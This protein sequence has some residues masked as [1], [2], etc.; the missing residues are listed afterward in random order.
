M[1]NL[2][3]KQ[4]EGGATELVLTVPP[5]QGQYIVVDFLDQY[6][7]TV[8]SIG[9]R[10]TPSTESQT[11][12]IAGPQSVYQHDK[13]VNIRG[14]EFRVVP[15]GTN[16]NWMLIRIRADTL[17][18]SSGPNSF[19]PNSTANVYPDVVQKFALNTLDEYLKNGNQPIFQSSFEYTFA[20]QQLKRSERWRSQPCSNRDT[21]TAADPWSSF[22]RPVAPSLSA[23]CPPRIAVSTA[24][25]WRLSPNGS[26]RKLMPPR[27]T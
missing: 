24:A 15:T 5:S 13:I 4:T 25:H 22:R 1:I 19:S 21:C 17:A 10:T 9:S 27:P 11:Y 3:G 14:K 20:K 6:I 2:S 26:L 8:G 18:P 23:R 7:N 12:L 16:L